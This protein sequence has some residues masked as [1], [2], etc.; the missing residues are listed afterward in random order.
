MLTANGARE[1]TYTAACSAFSA[2]AAN[3]TNLASSRLKLYCFN[4][5]LQVLRVL[6]VLGPDPASRPQ[7]SPGGSVSQPRRPLVSKTRRGHVLFRRGV[8]A[9]SGWGEGGGSRIG[10][11]GGFSLIF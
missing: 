4:A 11:S 10:D 9:S 3:D 7:Q 6:R 2:A 8:L 5:G 1:N